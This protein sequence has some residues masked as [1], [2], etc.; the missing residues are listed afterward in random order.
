MHEY[1]MIV[2]NFERKTRTHFFQWLDRLQHSGIC[3]EVYR[4]STV[5]TVDLLEKAHGYNS[6]FVVNVRHTGTY[7][8]G[9]EERTE[10]A[11]KDIEERIQNQA[12][13]HLVLI[14]THDDFRY[15]E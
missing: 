9:A 10:F 4:N 13:R 2:P 12:E 1:D 6:V 8:I 11:M 5:D 15:E 14:E 3:A 7:L